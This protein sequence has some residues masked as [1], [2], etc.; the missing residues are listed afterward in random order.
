ML[1]VLLNLLKNQQTDEAIR[2]CT[3]LVL[4]NVPSIKVK[5]LELLD[6]ETIA[7][8]TPLAASVL[9]SLG[10]T[11]LIHAEMLVLTSDNNLVLGPGITVGTTKVQGETNVAI[12]VGTRLL[13]REEVS[14][15]YALY[16]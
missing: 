12:F 5:V 15:T 4:E 1:S 11:P 13:E 8:S 6:A 7:G 9:A 16:H 2:I 10:D 3:Q 14:I